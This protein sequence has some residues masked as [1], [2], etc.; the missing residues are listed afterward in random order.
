M[1]VADSAPHVAGGRHHDAASQAFGSERSPDEV[2][3]LAA[4]LANQ[5][6]HVHVG[7]AGPADLAEQC[8]LTYTG[9]GEDPHA[10]TD[11]QRQ[12]GVDHAHTGGKLAVDWL[13]AE[14]GRRRS[15]DWHHAVRVDRGAAIERPAKRVDDAAE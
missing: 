1:A 12:H 5:P 8:A 11:T 10:L 14:R 9:T 6:D 4:T 13:A 2:I 3:E 7:L 15:V